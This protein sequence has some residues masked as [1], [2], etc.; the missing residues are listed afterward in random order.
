[1]IS[2]VLV[3]SCVSSS[4]DLSPAKAATT[5]QAVIR[6]S[7]AKQ[8]IARIRSEFAPRLWA[9]LEGNQNP[10]D[11]GYGE[12][13]VHSKNNQLVSKEIYDRCYEVFSDARSTRLSTQEIREK[14]GA[15]HPDLDIIFIPRTLY[16]LIYLQAA[17]QE[18]VHA[19]KFCRM[20]YCNAFS[21]PPPKDFSNKE[22]CWHLFHFRAEVDSAYRD[23]Q[24]PHYQAGEPLKTLAF[25]MNELI[26]QKIGQHSPM[27][28]SAIAKLTKKGV[29]FL[30]EHDQNFF[31][32]RFSKEDCIG[33]G[34]TV[35][36]A[37][38]SLGLPD[39]MRMG[40]ET[41]KDIRLVHD[42]VALECH[43]IAQKAFVLYRASQSP[44]KSLADLTTT[45]L[46]YGT[47]LF[48][49]A[50]ADPGAN[51]F[52]YAKFRSVH[53]IIVS[54]KT[55]RHPFYIPT[56]HPIRD[57]F[58]KGEFFHAR[59]VIPKESASVPEIKGLS[60]SEFPSLDP[61][62]REQLLNSNLSAKEL[63]ELVLQYHRKAF[64][65]SVKK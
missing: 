46:C 1:M 56:F 59:S 43:P 36:F 33:T 9:Q 39:R 3:P 24:Y 48:A 28:G 55:T 31:D 62:W 26:L 49:G 11:D 22:T 18:E 35:Y 10:V 58:S 16:E 50:F 13:I 20:Q 51:V 52:C 8:N 17:I 45:S 21:Y 27:S 5:L 30:A 57:L 41:L 4:Y 32:Q 65:L 7:L 12:Y 29:S 37:A 63:Y 60:R 40:I 19:E 53:A 42:A 15:I 54:A 34:P 44:I 25:R 23:S 2:N 47:S 61:L 14:I 64:S 38:R 6:R